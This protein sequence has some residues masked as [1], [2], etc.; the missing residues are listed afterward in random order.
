MK[1]QIAISLLLLCSA[2]TI[3]AQTKNTIYINSGMQAVNP[4]IVSESLCATGQPEFIL[5]ADEET[6]VNLQFKLKKEG[7]VKVL[8]KDRNN[9][10]V[11]AT[12]YVKNGENKLRLT[13]NENEEYTVW[14]SSADH[15]CMAV[16][17]TE[18]I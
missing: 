15:R 1:N 6:E 2:L 4:K 5:K 8:V 13:M 11:Y 7:S 10:V 12:E 16:R 9:H 3:N 18:A 17:F 14:L